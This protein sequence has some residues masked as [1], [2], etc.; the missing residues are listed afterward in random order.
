MSKVDLYIGWAVVVIVI[1][2]II[3]LEGTLFN[4]SRAELFDRINCALYC[5]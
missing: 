3:Q 2:I 4:S 1:I 5:C